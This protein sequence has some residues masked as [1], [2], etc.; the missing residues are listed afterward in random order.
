MKIWIK[1]R[2]RESWE[3]ISSIFEAQEKELEWKDWE[4]WSDWHSFF[5]D[6]S[7]LHLT[8]M[9]PELSSVKKKLRREGWRI[10]STV[11]VCEVSERLHV[12]E[13]FC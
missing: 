9:E 7:E 11:Q 3:E 4:E 12:T 13:R 2:A 10:N 1:V 6:R 5:K 8:G